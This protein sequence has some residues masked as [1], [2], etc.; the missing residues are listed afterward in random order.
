M[1]GEAHNV[2]FL[3]V[4]LL[5]FIIDLYKLKLSTVSPNV[6]DYPI[7]CIYNLF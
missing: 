5:V 1:Y 3:I 7:P 6:S 2:Q 4:S